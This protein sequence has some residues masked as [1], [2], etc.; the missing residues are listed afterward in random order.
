MVGIDE[1][2]RSRRRTIGLIVTEDARLVVRAPL[3]AS[4]DS[5]LRVVAEREEWIRGHQNRLREQRSRADAYEARPGGEILF[6]GRPRRLV[7]DDRIVRPHLEEELLYFPKAWLHAQEGGSRNE[8]LA[9]ALHG[10]LRREARRI[11]LERTAH[12][13]AATGLVPKAVSVSSARTRW[14]SCSADNHVR[15]SWRLV[16]APIEAVD[17]VV[18]HELC[19]IRHKNHGRDFW[20]LVGRHLPDCAVQR[21]W[22]RDNRQLLEIRAG[23]GGS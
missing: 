6:L 16:M 13:A 15:L 10:W 8:A 2:I 7:P 23:E 3:R 19:H 14:G 17:Y 4:M 20:N 21:R 5:I 22:L 1:L 11:L 12:H 18:V 9:D